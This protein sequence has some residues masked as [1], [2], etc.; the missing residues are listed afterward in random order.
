MAS[1]AASTGP[2]TVETVASNGHAGASGTDAIVGSNGSDH[3]AS[4]LEFLHVVGKLKEVKRT[5]WVR[6]GVKDPESVA[7][8]MYRMALMSFLLGKQEGVD[9]SKCIKM[10]LVHDLGESL[11]GD[12]VTEGEQSK[13]DKV[14]REEKIQMERDAMDKIS[15]LVG[16][17]VGK[18]IRDLWD[19]FEEGKSAEALHLRDLDK[20]EMVLQANEY[21]AAQGL[22]LQD[23]FSSTSGKF[24]TPMFKALD[25]EVRKRRA[26][27]MA[28]GEPAAKRA[29]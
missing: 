3:T 16:L 27:R 2:E 17:D 15:S 11:I 13:Q 12:L 25:A 5:G 19:E 24:K 1:K 28:E 8:H 9:S 23:F 7:D 4:V 22:D 6:T 10:A 21:E 14:T 26:A 29:Q 20:F 18:E